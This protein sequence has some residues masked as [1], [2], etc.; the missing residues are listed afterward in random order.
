MLA[1]WWTNVVDVGPSLSQHLPSICSCLVCVRLWTSCSSDIP[2]SYQRKQVR[3]ASCSIARANKVMS[4]IQVLM[5]IMM[6]VCS[7]IQKTHIQVSRSLAFKKINSPWD[8]TRKKFKKYVGIVLV[9]DHIRIELPGTDN[10]WHNKKGIY[11]S[12]T[13]RGSILDV[14]IWRL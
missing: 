7:G 1:Q 5:I 10:W 8:V 14:R 9:I 11:I 13:A 6:I 3:K 4:V 12:L 2:Y